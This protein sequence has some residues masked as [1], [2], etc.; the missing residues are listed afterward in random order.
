MKLG[1]TEIMKMLPH[2]YPFLLVD[3]VES[4]KKG[5]IVCKK[6]ITVNEPYFQ[7]H[8]PNV[9]IMPGVLLIECGAQAA[10]LMYILDSIDKEILTTNML[11]E[12]LENIDISEK[13]GY[14]AS[15]KQFKFKSLV[16]PGDTLMITCNM[17]I[18]L[19]KISEIQI[20]ISN[21]VRKEVAMGKILVS[22]K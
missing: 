14:L 21:Q 3:T 5:T 16:L 13:V 7:G 22:E 11:N 15:V 20:S 10:A 6:N 8:F 17:L 1:S 2:K 19:G 18:K 9:P 12:T 4:Y